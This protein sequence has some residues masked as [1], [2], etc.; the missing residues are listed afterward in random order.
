MV[1]IGAKSEYNPLSC[2]HVYLDIDATKKYSL[3]TEG[4]TDC[5][6]PFILSLSLRT[7]VL[8]MVHVMVWKYSNTDNNVQ[9]PFRE[10]L[11]MSVRLAHEPL[12]ISL[13]TY[14]PTEEAVSHRKRLCQY[15]HSEFGVKEVV[16]HKCKLWSL[17]TY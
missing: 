7:L 2:L 5:D 8:C 3:S 11:G 9:V 15:I 16:V 10:L 12:I 4:N 13:P 6:D 14:L 17:I 1:G